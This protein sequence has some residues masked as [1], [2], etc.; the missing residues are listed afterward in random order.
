MINQVNANRLKKGMTNNNDLP[1]RIELPSIDG[2]NGTKEIPRQGKKAIRTDDDFKLLYNRV[3]NNAIGRLESKGVAKLPK[4]LCCF[5]LW[6]WF[7][8]FKKDTKIL[9]QEEKDELKKLMD[10]TPNWRQSKN[11]NIASTND[12]GL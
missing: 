12:E 11:Q 10:S 9:A 4:Q 2:I 8:T 3:Q 6:I 1:S 5:I 7:N